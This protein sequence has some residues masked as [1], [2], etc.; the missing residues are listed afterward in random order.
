VIEGLRAE[1]AERTAADV[2]R[3]RPDE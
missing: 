2:A 1:G 3:A